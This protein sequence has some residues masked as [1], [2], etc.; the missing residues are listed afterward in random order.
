MKKKILTLFLI[1]S[2]AL[3]FTACSSSQ[4]S[5]QNSYTISVKKGIFNTK[6]FIPA[7]FATSANIEDSGQDSFEIANIAKKQ[8]IKNVTTNNDGSVSIKLSNT[9]Y[10]SFLTNVKIGIDD[11][12]NAFLKDNQDTC[13]FREISHDINL[14]E[15]NVLADSKEY[16]VSDVITSKPLYF[17]GVLYQSLSDISKKDI[18]T[19]VNILDKDTKNLI[20]TSNLTFDEYIDIL[21]GKTELSTEEQ[22]PITTTAT[23]AA[24]SATTTATT[25]S[26]PVTSN[27]QSTKQGNN[28]QITTT[29]SSSATATDT[30]TTTTA[31]TSAATTAT[32][33]TATTAAATPNLNT[34][35]QSKT[36]GTASTAATQNQGSTLGNYS[37]T[38]SGSISLSSENGGAATITA[39]TNSTVDIILKT[40]NFNSSRKSYIYIDGI[41]AATANLEAEQAL[42]LQGR[43]LTAGTHKVEVIQYSNDSTSGSVITYK[44]ASYQVKS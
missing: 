19:T 43:Y 11:Y 39:N 27:I 38:G 41:L 40:T 35:D 23:T 10:K 14:T 22:E 44:S 13:S 34:A 32:T 17:F 30:T 18:K 12:N 25:A 33:T 3:S 20:H 9:T 4:S 1:F 37:D 31:V 21:K 28:T 6:I 5:G 7:T 16:V 15:F 42:R 8:G 26:N 36:T 24:T 2:L 29:T